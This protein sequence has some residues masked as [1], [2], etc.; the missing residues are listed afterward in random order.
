[1]HIIILRYL[2]F[3][4]SI[5]VDDLLIGSAVMDKMQI[6]PAKSQLCGY[7]V[8]W[9]ESYATREQEDPRLSAVWTSDVFWES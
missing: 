8:N 6:C 2:D 4:L 7:R 1:M 9:D 5:H 3:V